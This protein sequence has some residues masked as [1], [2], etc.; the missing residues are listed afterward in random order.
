M[1]AVSTELLLH[2]EVRWLSKIKVLK[3]MYD[4]YEELKNFS[5]K[6]GK[7]N[8]RICLAKMRN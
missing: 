1:D 6:K 3:S 7:W 5:T 4:W 8:L 2:A